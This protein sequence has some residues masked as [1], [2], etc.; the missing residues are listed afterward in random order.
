MKSAS[1]PFFAALTILLS[2][3]AARTSPWL[4]PPVAETDLD[5]EGYSDNGVGYHLDWR[6]R[7][8]WAG[9]DS[10]F[11]R[12]YTGPAFRSGNLWMAVHI[13][14]A[15]LD[16]R[17]DYSALLSLWNRASFL[18]D[19]I[20]LSLQEDYMPGYKLSYGRGRL[21]Y[22]CGWNGSICGRPDNAGPRRYGFSGG[23]QAEHFDRLATVGPYLEVWAPFIA[24]GLGS[25]IGFQQGNFGQ[26]FFIS[27]SLELDRLREYAEQQDR[28]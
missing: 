28:E 26:R 15:D 13:G 4:Q 25:N 10:F 23:L 9:A 27:L 3:A 17:E 5:G 22:N 24:I 18:D 16:S 14:I 6:V 11:S 19:R 2:P 20:G 21:V 12:I 1:L 7:D 8:G